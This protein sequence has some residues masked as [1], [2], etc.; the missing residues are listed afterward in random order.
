M[1]NVIIMDAGDTNLVRGIVI[2]EDAVFAANA[3][4]EARMEAGEVR[5]DGNCL[6]SCEWLPADEIEF[7]EKQVHKNGKTIVWVRGGGMSFQACNKLRRYYMD[8]ARDYWAIPGGYQAYTGNEL[9]V[10]NR[11]TGEIIPA[12]RVESHLV[13]GKAF[14]EAMW[15]LEKE[16]DKLRV[17]RYVEPMLRPIAMQRILYA[18]VELAQKYNFP[19]EEFA[20]VFNDPANRIAHGL[21]PLGV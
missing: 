17:R 14:F 21:K 12:T 8:E 4:I 9:V 6:R 3:Q 2:T 11:M 20:R 16:F 1:R 10:A 7:T 13:P 19:A 18:Q 15:E 5:E